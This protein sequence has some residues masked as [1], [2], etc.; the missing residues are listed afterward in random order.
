MASVPWTLNPQC[1][2]RLALNE[3]MSHQNQGGKINECPFLPFFVCLFFWG[4]GGGTDRTQS[5]RYRGSLRKAVV[6]VRQSMSHSVG[7]LPTDLTTAV[8]MIDRAVQ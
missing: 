7:S 5:V 8:R 1:V 2:T 6:V 4:G 3:V